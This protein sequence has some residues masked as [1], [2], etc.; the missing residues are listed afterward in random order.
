[1]S[2][3]RNDIPRYALMGIQDLEDQYGE[4]RFIFD[5]NTKK[6]IF[7]SVRLPQNMTTFLKFENTDNSHEAWFP[8]MEKDLP[9]IFGEDTKVFRNCIPV[10][11]Y[12]Q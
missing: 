9:L 1:M 12:Q 7:L 3:R 2:C 4:I 11:K 8:F 6:I 5:P 10:T